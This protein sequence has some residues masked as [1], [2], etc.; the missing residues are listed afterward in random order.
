M[1]ETQYYVQRLINTHKARIRPEGEE[2]LTELQRDLY[3]TIQ[4]LV[5]NNPRILSRNEIEEEYNRIRGKNLNL[6][7]TDFCYNLVN[8]GPDFETK[9]LIRVKRGRFEFVD[10]HWPAEDREVTITWAPRG[11][12]VPEEL[13]N[14]TFTVGI[15]HKGE[16][17]WDFTEL[18]EYL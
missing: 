1:N 10:F 13:R 3:D 17:R 16:Y 5:E 2:E 14:N 7:P 11:R 9:F 6:L 8:V 18:E 4:A 12:C 15:Y